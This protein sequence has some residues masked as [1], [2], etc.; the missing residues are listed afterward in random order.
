MD[1]LFRYWN[2]KKMQVEVRYWDSS[3]M[4]YCTSH[5]LTNHFNVSITDLNHSKILQVSMDVP[6]V[7]SDFHRVVQSNREELE[8]PKL[9]DIDSCSLH[10][11]MTH[12]KRELNQLI[13]KLRKLSRFFCQKKWQYQYHWKHCIPTFIFRNQMAWDQKGGGKIDQYLAILCQNF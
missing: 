3:Y 5:D 12:S 7:N 4:E 6:S 11:I 9:I 8:L 1:L 2:E 10:T 13:G